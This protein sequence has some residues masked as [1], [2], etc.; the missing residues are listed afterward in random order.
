MR[1]SAIRWDRV[2][3]VALLATL[4]VIALSYLSPA[5]HWIEQSRTAGEQH[6]QLDQLLAK[7][8]EL[9]GTLK[10]LKS[11]GALEREARRLG[12]VR[13][14]ERSYVIENLPGR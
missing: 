9:K 4:A 10:Q 12:M 13:Q 3:R 5:R 2:G 14:G 8:R 6:S 1:R 11:P 7:N